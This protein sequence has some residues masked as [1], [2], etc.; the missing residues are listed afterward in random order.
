MSRSGLA[1][2]QFCRVSLSM[3]Q[4]FGFIPIQ[5]STHPST[6][7]LISQMVTAGTRDIKMNKMDLCILS[8]RQRSKQAFIVLIA[9]NSNLDLV[10]DKEGAR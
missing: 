10:E 2:Q 1:F 4:C 7:L 6:Y 3:N 5:P 9:K 8:L